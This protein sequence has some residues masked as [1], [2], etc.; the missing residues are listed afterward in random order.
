[1]NKIS[2]RADMLRTK[3]ERLLLFFAF[4]Q[5]AQ[6]YKIDIAGVVKLVD[7]PDSKSDLKLL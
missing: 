7:A 3:G 1:M 6:Y 2:L 4:F 5:T